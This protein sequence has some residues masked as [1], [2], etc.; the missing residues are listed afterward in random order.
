MKLVGN[1]KLEEKTVKSVVDGNKMQN[2]VHSRSMDVEKPNN[3][4]W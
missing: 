2:K 3:L 1:T 4:L